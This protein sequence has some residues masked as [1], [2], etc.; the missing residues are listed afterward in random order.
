M[1][2]KTEKVIVLWTGNT[3]MYLTP[4]I[5]TAEDLMAK[6]RNN[7]ILPASVLYCIATIEEQAVYLNGSPQNTLHP[8]MIEYAKQKGG[9]L[10]GS[11]FKSG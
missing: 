4:E 3:E 6:V 9:K 5:D 10:G 8:G 11:D 7:D 1:K 2:E